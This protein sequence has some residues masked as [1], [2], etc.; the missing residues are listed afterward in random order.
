MFPNLRFLLGASLATVLLI[1]LVGA[2]MFAIPDPSV[3]TE[4]AQISR[5][6]LSQPIIDDLRQPFGLSA[7]AR[8]NGELQRLLA[9]PSTP[10]RA[11]APEP[12]AGFPYELGPRDSSIADTLPDEAEAVPQPT[13]AAP[14]GMPGLPAVAPADTTASPDATEVAALPAPAL[15]RADPVPPATEP[16]AA[17][18][19]TEPKILSASAEPNDRPVDANDRRV[20]QTPAP[21]ADASANEPSTT[22]SV[23]LAPP[24]SEP[25]TEVDLAALADGEDMPLP[26]PKPS[27]T[28]ASSEKRAAPVRLRQ[29]KVTSSKPRR[30][31][32]GTLRPPPAPA[33]VQAFP[34]P[35]YDTG[36]ND[37]Y[38]AEGKRI[39]TVGG[40]AATVVRSHAEMART[41][42]S[43]TGATR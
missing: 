24:A 28:P 37:Q 19:P 26:R 36:F 35:F 20:A 40:H 27:L 21:T 7:A 6:L 39:D 31:I 12:G 10:V 13:A 30:T 38:D 3:R 22:A 2:G 16:A 25:I 34:F 14:P 1:A 43:S 4:V 5:P 8:R 23:T 32:R 9:L 18:E 29:V 42:A 33:P 15:P 11:Y 17:V 41:A